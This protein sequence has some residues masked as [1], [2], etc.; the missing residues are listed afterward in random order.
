M[1]YTIAPFDT[2]TSV[3]Q[4]FGVPANEL[5]VANNLTPNSVIFP[6]MVIIIPPKQPRPP[7]QPQPPVFPVPPIGSLPPQNRVYIV[8]RGD[9]LWSIARRFGV[10]VQRLM[11]TNNLTFPVIFP[12][13]RLIIPIRIRP[14]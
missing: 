12:G 13:Q 2:I 9:S 6:G 3:S 11:A 4:K 5:L 8:R 10:S 1:T 14:L 7:F